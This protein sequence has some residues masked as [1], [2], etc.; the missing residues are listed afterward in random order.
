MD[1]VLERETENDG[2]LDDP[3]LPWGV[4]DV[5][6]EDSGDALIAQNVEVKDLEDGTDL[7]FY[8]DDASGG[9]CA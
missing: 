4:Y 5:C 2:M 3:G 7:V 8:M 1:V 9:D 6:V